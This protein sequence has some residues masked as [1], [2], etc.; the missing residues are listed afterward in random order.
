MDTFVHSAFLKNLAYCRVR[1]WAGI[2]PYDALNS[3]LLTAVP[4][5]NSRLPRIALTQALRRSPLNIRS[6]LLIGPTQNPKALA[7]FLSALLKL[8]RLGVRQDGDEAGGMVERL[9]ALRSTGTPY[10]CWGYSFPWQTRSRLVPKFAPNLVCTCFVA[11][12]LLDTYERLRQSPCLEMAVSAAD[13]IVNELYWTDDQQRAG[14]AYPLPDMRQ[15]IPNANFLAAAL[16]ARVSRITG[17]PKYLA[18]AF[19]TARYS[20][21]QQ[22][23]DGAWYYGE[24]A[25]QQWID[26]FHTGYNLCA[27]RDFDRYAETTEFE[28]RIKNGL[29]FYKTRFFRPDGAVAYFDDR[30]YPVD[31]HC[32]AQSILTLIALRDLDPQSLP[33]ARNICHWALANLWD[34]RGFFY[35]RQ[36]RFYT[37]R[38]SYMRWTQ[39][40][41]LLAL[42]SLLEAEAVDSE[43]VALGASTRV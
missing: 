3:R 22:R 36:L 9:I 21:G 11:G 24:A 31:S 6:L 41:M 33:L 29:E 39:A 16:L 8:P 13:Y 2:D 23:S 37:I 15:R 40:W 42:A 20:A 1:D 4:F 12:A 28:A 43:S 17:D 26:N 30:R 19:A 14:F 32:I 38:T 27:L 35:Y 7:C 18:P 5:L 25:T 34:E 10:W